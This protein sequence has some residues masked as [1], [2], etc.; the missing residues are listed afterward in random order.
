[1]AEPG[2]YVR[3]SILDTGRGMDSETRSRIFEPF[4]TT[5]LT[6]KGT[7]LGLSTAYGIIAQSAGA[8]YV[9]SEPGHGA[10]FHIYLP[11]ANGSA[12]RR[13]SRQKDVG[14]FIGDETVLIVEDERGVRS[15]ASKVLCKYGYTPLIARNGAEAVEICSNRAEKIDVMLTDVVMPGLTGQQLVDKVRALKPDIKILFMSG[16]PSDEILNYDLVD[17]E[18]HFLPKPFS[19]TMLLSKVRKILDE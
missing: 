6:G 4:F 17:W 7:G 5:K 2:Q 11:R 12:P 3:W 16:Y 19:T 9:K 15:L 18:K 1:V 13:K 14:D 8:I 10:V